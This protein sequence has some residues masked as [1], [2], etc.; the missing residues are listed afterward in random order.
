MTIVI[1]LAPGVRGDGAA[2]VGAMLAAAGREDLLVVVVAPKPW[3]ST[4]PPGDEFRAAQDKITAQSLDRAR[5]IIRDQVPVTCVVEPARS[6]ATGLIQVAEK[7]GAS[8]IVLGSSARGV[9]GVVSLGGVAEEFAQPGH[10]DLLRPGRIR[11]RPERPS[12]P[13]HR[14]IRPRRP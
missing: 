10:P 5:A 13:G 1:G 4:G 2:R 11:R 6:V 3:P 14:G 12:Y 9:I 8:L 7:H